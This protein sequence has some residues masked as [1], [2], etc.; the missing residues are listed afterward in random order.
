MTE[1]LAEKIRNRIQQHGEGSQ[2]RISSF[3]NSSLSKNTSRCDALGLMHLLRQQ[4][5]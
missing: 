2:R 4:A 1:F 3:N 5:L